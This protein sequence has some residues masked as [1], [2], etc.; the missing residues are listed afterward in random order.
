MCVSRKYGGE[1]KLRKLK[2]AEEMQGYKDL[3]IERQKLFKKFL[4]NFYDIWE[5]PEKHQPVSIGLDRGY[6]K[7]T[8]EGNSSLHIIKPDQW[9]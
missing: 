2:D 6:L 7:V 8:F 9:Y 5:N 1:L 4:K 3:V